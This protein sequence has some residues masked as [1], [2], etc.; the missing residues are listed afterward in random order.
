M[1]EEVEIE[2]K[3][4][5]ETIE[6]LHEERKEREQEQR[7]NSWMRYIALTTALLAV[8]A[9]IGALQSA[10]LIAESLMDQLKA[11]DTWNQYQASRLKDHLYTLSAQ[12][13]VDRGIRPASS[14]RSSAHP[15]R[16]GSVAQSDPPNKPRHEQPAASRPSS[17][18]EEIA[19]QAL[20]SEVRLRQYIQQ[21]EKERERENEL[22]EEARKLEHESERKARVHHHFANSVALI[23]VAISLAAVAALTRIKSVWWLSLAVGLAGIAF[24]VI[25][26]ASLR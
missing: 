13:L 25:G 15:A 24:F 4:L 7:R 6:E 2:T 21:A 11:S 20:P 17:R 3:D 22:S 18:S 26:A 12:A 14:A 5:Q 16:Q 1:S 19:W 8:F 10:A 9:A 23:Q